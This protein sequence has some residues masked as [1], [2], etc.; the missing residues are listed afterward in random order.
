MLVMGVVGLRGYGLLWLG[1][2]CFV[3]GGLML[4]QWLSS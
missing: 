4:Q 2:V 1:G 3:C